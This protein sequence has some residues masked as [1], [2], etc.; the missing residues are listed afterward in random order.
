MWQHPQTARAEVL[1]TL[2]NSLHSAVLLGLGPHYLCTTVALEASN[3][4]L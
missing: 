2:L 3:S 4:G 1:E